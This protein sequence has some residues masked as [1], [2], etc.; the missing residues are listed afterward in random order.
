MLYVPVSLMHPLMYLFLFY[1]LFV[2]LLVFQDRISLYSPDCPEIHIVGQA[3][4]ELAEIPFLRLPSAE[5]QGR[6]HHF[7]AHQCI[8]DLP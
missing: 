2:Y 8:L 1:Y 4:L 6:C 7:P 5:I 3:T